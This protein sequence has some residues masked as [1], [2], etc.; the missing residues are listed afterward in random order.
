[1]HSYKRRGFDNEPHFQCCIK[2]GEPE[3]K[4]SNVIT[5]RKIGR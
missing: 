4:F 1:M 2:I 5:V 3:K